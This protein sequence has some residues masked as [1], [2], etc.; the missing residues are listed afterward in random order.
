M[1]WQRGR[2][3][4]I[5]EPLFSCLEVFVSLSIWLRL[6]GAHSSKDCKENYINQCKWKYFLNCKVSK[7]FVFIFKIIFIV[8]ITVVSIFPPSSSSAHLNPHLHSQ[9]PHSCPCP[10]VIHTCF[11]LVPF[12]SFH[13]HP[14]SPSPLVTFSLIHVSLSVVLFCSLVYVVH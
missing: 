14:P 5:S 3:Q 11:C 7:T 4:S 6:L 2:S 1:W 10:W 9:F 12:P 8:T 13:H